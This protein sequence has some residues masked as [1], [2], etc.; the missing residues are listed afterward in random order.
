MSRIQVL[1]PIGGGALEQAL[2]GEVGYAQYIQIKRS[3]LSFLYF[4]F[5]FHSI[6][7]HR[8]SVH[9]ACGDLEILSKP[10]LRLAETRD[11]R[12]GREY[13]LHLWCTPEKATGVAQHSK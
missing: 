1:D 4:G 3:V 11:N 12:G 9:H 6:A 10:I 13:I 5:S 8:F 2:H 7:T